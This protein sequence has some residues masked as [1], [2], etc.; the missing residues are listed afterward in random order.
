MAGKEPTHA[1]LGVSISQVNS[2]TAQ[3][4]NL[5]T[6]KGAYIAEIYE[7]SG[8]ANS[9]LQVGDII[10][11]I[12]GKS[13]T[14]TTDVTLDVRAYNVGDTV[15]VTVN[16]NGQTVDVPVTLTSDENLVQSSSD[17]QQQQLQQSPNGGQGGSGNGGYSN[18]ELEYLLRMLG[19]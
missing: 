11:A 5:S 17:S 3:R 18:E 1:A 2:Q 7:G 14:S 10:T 12:N 16:R 6:T 9:D 19:M 4:Y 8:A 13:V 15:T